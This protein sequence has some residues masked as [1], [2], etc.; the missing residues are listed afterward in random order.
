MFKCL[1]V[2]EKAKKLLKAHKTSKNALGG[3]TDGRTDGWTD[4]QSDL[5]SPVHATKNEKS[6]REEILEK[7]KAHA[8][9]S[10][11]GVAQ[12]NIA[13]KHLWVPW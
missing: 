13:L 2:S 3:R 9:S 8:T 10:K 1:N 7:S 5:Q 4:G 12:N 6:V 11:E